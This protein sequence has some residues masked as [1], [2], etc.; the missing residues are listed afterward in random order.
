MRYATIA[1]AAVC[2]LFAGCSEPRVDGTDE[3]SFKASVKKVKDGLSDERRQKFD[4]AV[5]VI[6]TDAIGLGL[7]GSLDGE[8]NGATEQTIYET[9]DGMTASEII[10][11]GDSIQS[12][13]DSV[14]AARDSIKAA[15]KRK[16]AIEEIRELEQ[17][18]K[19]AKQ[20]RQ[21]LEEFRV[22]RARFRKIDREFRGEQAI[23]SLTVENGT[24]EAISRVYFEGT[25]KT[26]DRSVPW[27]SGTFNYEIP[28]GLE[29]GEEATWNLRPNSFG[30][31][32]QM[33]E[34]SDAV[35]TAEPYKLDGP[36]GELLY[37]AEFNEKDAKRLKELKG[38]YA[39]DN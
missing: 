5:T 15:R 7:D 35:F 24:S 17:K 33:E 31:W 37:A 39:L 27:H 19:E 25:Y 21:K 20:A 29:P 14:Q 22:K 36:E 6:T 38:Q 34:R 9:L 26:P 18:R 12:A 23:I 3:E 13:R 30:E 1:T 11:K 10:A 16:E 2:L 28:G 8:S 32:G 4:D